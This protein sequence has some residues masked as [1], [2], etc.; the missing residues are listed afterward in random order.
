[1]EDARTKAKKANVISLAVS[2]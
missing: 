2:Q 1:M